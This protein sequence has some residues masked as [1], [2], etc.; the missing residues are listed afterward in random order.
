MTEFL[1]LCLSSVEDLS[2]H[3]L[4]LESNE[5]P[6]FAPGVILLKDEV[7]MSHNCERFTVRGCS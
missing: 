3:A 7:F 2:L 5:A 4:L 1:A 6:E